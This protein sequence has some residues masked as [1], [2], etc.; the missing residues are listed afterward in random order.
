MEEGKLCSEHMTF[1][2]MCLWSQLCNSQLKLVDARELQIPE[3]VPIMHRGLGPRPALERESHRFIDSMTFP[4][5]HQT[6]T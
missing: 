6:L 4:L 1:L 2:F 5:N 3:I